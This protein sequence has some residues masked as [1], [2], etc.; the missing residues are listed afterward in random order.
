MKRP[1]LLLVLALLLPAC[2]DPGARQQQKELVAQASGLYSQCRF[3]ETAAAADRAI[4]MKM[5]D[6]GAYSFA[7][8]LKARSMEQT[9][10]PREA[11]PIYRQLVELA[12]DVNNVDEARKVARTLD[13]MM[14]DC[15][16]GSPTSGQEGEAAPSSPSPGG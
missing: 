1:V 4:A 2:G 14:G 10:R 5:A 6:P 8:M 3:G 11:E 7:L 15:A 12:Q 13:V 16:A 9:G